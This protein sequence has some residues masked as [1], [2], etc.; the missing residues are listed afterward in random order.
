MCTGSGKVDDEEEVRAERR[1]AT[2]GDLPETTRM[3][4]M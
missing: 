2:L 3:S 4:I 1:D